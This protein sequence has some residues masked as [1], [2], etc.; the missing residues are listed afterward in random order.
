MD[1]LYSEPKI[2]LLS[3]EEMKTL[4]KHKYLNA[5]HEDQVLEAICNWRVG[6]DIDADT[7]S[8][9]QNLNWQYVSM[10]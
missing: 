4:L 6:A 10:K 7:T 8:I 3:E 9:F 1:V 5:K 2:R